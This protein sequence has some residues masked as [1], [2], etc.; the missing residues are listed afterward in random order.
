MS[1]ESY[2]PIGG[3]TE[4]EHGTR[5]TCQIKG[6]REDRGSKGR[7]GGKES[8]GGRQALDIEYLLLVSFF[9]RTDVFEISMQREL[10][11]GPVFLFGAMRV[12]YPVKRE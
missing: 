10:P 8:K 5:L 7:E 9:R 1:S 12:A 11:R 2:P 6:Y 4:K 3:L